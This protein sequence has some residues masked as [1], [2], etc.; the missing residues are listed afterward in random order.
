VDAPAR[1]H[2]PGLFVCHACDAEFPPG[3][4]SYRACC[5]PDHLFLSTLQDNVDD[6]VRKGR[7]TAG[8]RNPS[9]TRPDR[10]ARGAQN[11]KTKLT[12]EQ[13]RLIRAAYTAGGVTQEAL[14]E[15]FGVA[16]PA[17]WKILQ[18]RN[19]KYVTPDGQGARDE[20][21]PPPPPKPRGRPGRKPQPRIPCICEVCGKA[22]EVTQ[23]NYRRG[24][25]RRCSASCGKKK[26]LAPNCVCPRCGT[27]VY[28]TP[29]QLA[30]RA[31]AYCSVA[32]AT[33]SRP[34]EPLWSRVWRRID[35]G[36]TGCWEWSGGTDRGGYGVLSVG[37]NGTRRP[38]H[39]TR[40]VWR[41]IHGAFPTNAL[42]RCDNPLC[43]RPSHLFDGSKADNNRD[44]VA[45]GR[46]RPAE[47]AARGEQSGGAKLTEDIIREM[48]RRH[49]AGEN[50]CVLARAYGVSPQ[51]SYAACAGRTWKHVR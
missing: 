2:P 6:M 25:G 33:R 35:Y 23:A 41:L 1:P 21:P 29:S 46:G 22:F 16:K 34:T 15:R 10:L 49:A 8:D 30:S 39:V 43:A 27:A 51:A 26:M 19:W 38:Y 45:K 42:H 17:I 14:A 12:E 37:E 4:T 20:Q 3:D 9:R 48:R 40:L 13:V 5:N 18:H 28:R 11:R 36:G 32:C 24:R 50:C 31:N 47:K 7:S 44:M